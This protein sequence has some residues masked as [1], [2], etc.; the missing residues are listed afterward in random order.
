MVTLTLNKNA[1]V[2]VA[3]QCNLLGG[4]GELYRIIL[5]RSI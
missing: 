5:Q 3:V 1:S 4:C 2:A